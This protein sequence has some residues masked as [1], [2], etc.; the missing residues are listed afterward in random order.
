MYRYL[1][2]ILFLFLGSNV[3]AKNTLQSLFNST[4]SGRNFSIIYSNILDGKNEIGGGLRFNINQ[5]AHPDDQNNIFYKRLYATNPLHYFGIEAFYNRYIFTNLGNM[6]PYLFYDIQ[7]TYST[8]FNRMCLPYTYADD[9]EMLYKKYEEYFGPYTWIEQCVGLGFNVDIFRNWFF[10]QKVGIGACFIFGKEYQ[11]PSTW[12]GFSW[13][14][15]LLYNV[16]IG[17]RF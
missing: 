2:L 10:T 3:S 8:T 11:I 7:A 1:I 6:K 16:G 14:V 17:Y 9:G 4:H 5:Y 13:E 12:S 15:G